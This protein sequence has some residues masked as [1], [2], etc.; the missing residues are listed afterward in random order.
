MLLDYQR[1]NFFAVP[2]ECVSSLNAVISHRLIVFGP[3]VSL[4]FPTL[5]IRDSDS[6]SSSSD[7]NFVI[8]CVPFSLGKTMLSLLPPV[9]WVLNPV[10]GEAGPGHCG[11]VG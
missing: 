11:S 10:K 6:G 8:F 5:E 1:V 2:L 3:C 9:I 4:S 7:L